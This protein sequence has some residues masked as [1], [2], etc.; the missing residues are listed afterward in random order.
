MDVLTHRVEDG[1]L[2]VR[3]QYFRSNV[4]NQEVLS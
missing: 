4:P 1:K 3:F 2:L